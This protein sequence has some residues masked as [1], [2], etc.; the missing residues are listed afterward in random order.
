[1]ENNDIA[2]QDE[3]T[4]RARIYEDIEAGSRF[5][6]VLTALD[7]MGMAVLTLALVITFWIWG[8]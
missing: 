4:R 2:W 7:Y 3:L 5:E 8:A 6:G 1:M